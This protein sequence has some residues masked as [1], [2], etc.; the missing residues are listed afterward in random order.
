MQPHLK[1]LVHSLAL[2]LTFNTQL[3]AGPIQ[4]T[5]DPVRAL[6]EGVQSLDR[7]LEKRRKTGD[8]EGTTPDLMFIG[9]G[10]INFHQSLIER[11]DS[12]AA[13]QSAAKLGFVLRLLEMTA[14]AKQ[15]FEYALQHAVRAKVWC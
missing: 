1:A 10:L 6:Q 2:F 4:Q 9:R 8:I 13:L 12:A 5:F 14:Q 3:V 15:S 7:V 11:G